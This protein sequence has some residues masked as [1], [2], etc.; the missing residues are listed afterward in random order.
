V[1]NGGLN[2]LEQ[3]LKAFCSSPIEY[4]RQDQVISVNAVFGKTDYQAD[5]GSG[6][7]IESFVWDFLIQAADL[8]TEPKVGDTIIVNGRSFE[9]MKLAGQGCWRWTGPNQKTYRI[10]TRDIGNDL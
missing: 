6:M 5:T 2:W 10:H 3:K 4:R 8:G 1:L 7:T 9:V